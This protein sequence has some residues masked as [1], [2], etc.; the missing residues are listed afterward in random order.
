[1]S[2]FVSFF[3]RLEGPQTVGR[4][5]AFWS[6]FAVV[7]MIAVAY[8][9]F[10]DGYTV[11]N[12]VYFFVW[13]FIALSLCLI[14]GYGGSLSF[15]QTAFFGIAGYGYGVLTLNFGSA[16]GF[17]LVAL[18]AAVAI[19]ALFA[20]LL[21]YFMFFGRIAGVFLGIVTLAVTLMLERFM[22]QTAG[23]EWHIGSARLNGFNGMSAMPPLTI[24]WPGEPIVLFADVG[25]Y[26]FVLGL[27]VFVYL[28]LR[29]L[30][31]SSFGNVIVAIREN[32]ERAEMLG[33][34]VRKYQLI[35]FVIGAV[36]AGISGVLYTAWG[37]YI[38]PS[39]MGMTA[40]ALPLIWVA[41][42]GRSDLT[43]TVVGTLVVLAA[44]QA[45]TIYGS[46]YALVFMGVLLVLTVLIAPNGLVLGTMNWLGR[47]AARITQRAG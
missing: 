34:D 47:L 13:V 30:M 5:P 36:L 17:T 11:G 1:M 28:A 35:T 44:F 41:V 7:M 39:S 38:T 42:G 26:Y 43:S 23:P 29:I 16:Y 33:Y 10:S 20:A 32:P 12:T 40:A 45:L 9:L 27:L 3:R 22:A 2:G 6:L 4:G 24:P 37:Q 21:G 18:V 8:P 19:A 14:W 46:Q 25:L 15:G 31:N